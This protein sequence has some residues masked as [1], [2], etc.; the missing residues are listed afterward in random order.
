V[1]F[2][3]WLYRLLP[4]DAG[5]QQLGVIWREGQT[6]QAASTVSN[7]VYIVPTDKCLVL[8][9]F[10]ARWEVGA[11]Q[12]INRRRVMADPPAGTTRYNILDSEL[13]ANTHVCE[14]WQGEVVIPGG[15]SI[16]AEGNFSAGANANVVGIEIHGFLIPRGTFIFG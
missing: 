2:P 7:V 15:W 10:A 16:R 12:N 4:G 9:N 14:N 1:R 13:D 5:T 8:T 11:A 6:T 3:E